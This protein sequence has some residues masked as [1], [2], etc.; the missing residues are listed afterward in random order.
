[1]FG[2]INLNKPLHLTSHD[3]VARVRWKL[4]IRKVGHCGTLDPLAEG[5]L[6]VC[7]GNATRLIE[8]FSDDKCY[9]AEVTL[10]IT[11]L[12]WD[13]EGEIFQTVSASNYTQMQVEEALCQFQGLIMQQVPPH[14]AVHVKGK[15]LY[16]YARKGIPVELP[17]RET[18]IFEMRL[19]GFQQHNPEHPVVTLEIHCSKGTYIRSIAKALGDNLGCGAFLSALTRTHHGKFSLEESICL[20]DF[21]NAPHP[22]AYLLNPV[23][24]L[25]LPQFDLSNEN[26]NKVGHGMKLQ[27][28]ELEQPIR[29]NQHYLLLYEG[30]PTAIAIGEA[31]GRLKP[32]KVFPRIPV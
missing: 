7:V 18:Q 1:V 5:V 15:K 30:L 2:V 11:T 22:E 21:L 23:S 29:N 31:S 24:Y 26:M 32:L 9:R 3:V 13:A 27:P 6:P 16:E 19:A 28:D 17:I 20:E 25:P 14:A 4:G 12:T 8:Y 10:G